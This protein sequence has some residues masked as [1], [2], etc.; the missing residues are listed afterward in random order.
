MPSLQAHPAFCSY[1][2]SCAAE[3]CLPARRGCPRRDSAPSIVL[4]APPAK[5]RSQR[6][7]DA[8]AYWREGDIIDLR[9]GVSVVLGDEGIIEPI[10][11]DATDR[12]LYKAIEEH[13]VSSGMQ[14]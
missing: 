6:L 2:K 5:T 14:A 9:T 10:E 3:C 7:P 12:R 1:S 13:S 8:I 11:S 4:L